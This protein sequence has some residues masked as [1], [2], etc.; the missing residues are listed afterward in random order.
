M[1]LKWGDGKFTFRRVGSIIFS[2]LVENWHHNALSLKVLDYECVPT[3]SD[4]QPDTNFS[5]LSLVSEIFLLTRLVF[6]ASAKLTFN[7]VV[8]F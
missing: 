6:L 8:I 2:M 1:C 7:S 5:T 4:R 3:S